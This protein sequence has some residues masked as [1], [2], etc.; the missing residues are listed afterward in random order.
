MPESISR[1]ILFRFFL[2]KLKRAEQSSDLGGNVDQASSGDS[3]PGLISI[4]NSRILP[5]SRR[6]GE[7][8][9][10]RERKRGGESPQGPNLPE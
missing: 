4:G 5:R 1:I 6:E 7:R 3:F 8:E 10:E 2:N 9:R